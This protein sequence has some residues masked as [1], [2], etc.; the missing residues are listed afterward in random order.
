MSIIERAEEWQDQAC[1]GQE[2][3]HVTFSAVV[4]CCAHVVGMKVYN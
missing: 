3:N 1:L 4:E 2:L